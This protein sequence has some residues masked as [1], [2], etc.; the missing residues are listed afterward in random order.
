M[1]KQIQ[2]S[3]FPVVAEMI[4][5]SFMTVAEELNLTPENCPRHTA[6]IISPE[7]LHNNYGCGWLMYGLYEDDNKIVG[8]VSLSK[9]DEFTY[10]LHNLG[11]LPEYR[12]KGY[13]KELIDFCKCKVKELDGNKIILGMI[14]E[15]TRLKNWYMQNGFVTTGT[16]KYE[17]FPFTA[18]YM[19]WKN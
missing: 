14:E 18:G 9:I 6:F 10:E 13:G 15:N 17:I 2:I 4:R 12:R 3:E 1:I 11:V 16:H 5:E 8:Y 19:E 7:R